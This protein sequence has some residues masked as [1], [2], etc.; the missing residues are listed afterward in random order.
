MYACPRASQTTLN[1]GYGRKNFF[2]STSQNQMNT[3]FRPCMMGIMIQTL[4]VA[5]AQN[6]LHQRAHNGTYVS[7]LLVLKGQVG[8]SR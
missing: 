5:V 4:S 7:L 6:D 1:A 3:D 2:L 8:S